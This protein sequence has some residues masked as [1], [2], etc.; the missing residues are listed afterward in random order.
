MMRE[1]RLLGLL[2]L[3]CMIAAPV[4]AFAATSGLRPYPRP[5]ISS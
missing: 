5:L 4:T 2:L 1:T 3:F